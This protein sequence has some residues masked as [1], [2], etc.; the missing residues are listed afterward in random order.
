MDLKGDQGAG[1]LIRAHP[2]PGVVEF[3]L[4]YL[5]ID[6]Q[7]DYERIRPLILIQVVKC[8]KHVLFPVICSKS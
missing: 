6:T 1:K 2:N 8:V 7:G 4:G 5:D 3:E